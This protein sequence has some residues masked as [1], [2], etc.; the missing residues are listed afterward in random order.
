VNIPITPVSLLTLYPAINQTIVIHALAVLVDWLGEYPSRPLLA[1][2][3]IINN[4]SWLWSSHSFYYI[5]PALLSAHGTPLLSGFL[6]H[7]WMFPAPVC[8]WINLWPPI[9]RV[10]RW[11][12]LSADRVLVLLSHVLAGLAMFF[13]H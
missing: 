4:W 8:L 11:R 3:K 1:T 13:S 5:L 12:K 2:A 10:S 6:L 7:H 9:V